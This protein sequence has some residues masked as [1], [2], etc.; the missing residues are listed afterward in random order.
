MKISVF[1][2]TTLHIYKQTTWKP[3]TG[4]CGLRQT[5]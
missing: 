5:D 2:M 3:S 1:G 4:K